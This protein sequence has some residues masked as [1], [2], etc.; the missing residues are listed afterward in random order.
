MC[1]ICA[2]RENKYYFTLLYF[3]LLY[4]GSI[5]TPTDLQL[6]SMQTIIVEFCIGKLKVA[7]NRRYLAQAEGGLGI[8][9]L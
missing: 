9:N 2:D 5:L 3:T 7:K 1:L 6:N 8:L 4:I